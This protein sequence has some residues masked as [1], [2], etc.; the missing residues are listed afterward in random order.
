MVRGRC[1]IPEQV[2]D[3]PEYL[4]KDERACAFYCSDNT[5][6]LWGWSCLAEQL[7]GQSGAAQVCL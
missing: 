2:R 1:P 7:T 5:E 4:A 3:S 6:I